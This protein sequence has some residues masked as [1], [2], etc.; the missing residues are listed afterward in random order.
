M[1]NPERKEAVYGPT[2]NY[3]AW[4]SPHYP[5]IPLPDGT[6]LQGEKG[7]RLVGGI[8]LSGFFRKDGTEG[9]YVCDLSAMGVRPA[10]M[11]SRGFGR[12]ISPSHSE[13]FINGRPLSISQ[14][15]KKV[16]F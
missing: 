13:L 1:S 10:P 6:H 11:V 9:V 16:P 2:S 8:R 15:P 3:K 4:H 14:F 5:P 12:K 7:A